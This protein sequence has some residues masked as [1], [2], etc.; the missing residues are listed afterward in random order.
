MIITKT[1][2]S[3]QQKVGVFLMVDNI[4]FSPNLIKEGKMSL[5]DWLELMNSDKREQ[6]FPN[7]CFPSDDFL[8]QYI[9][10][11]EKVGE[12]DFKSLL[13]MLLVNTGS[14][15]ID[16]LNRERF[17]L[18]KGYLDDYKNEYYRRLIETDYA[19]EGLTWIID[20]LPHF[21]KQALQVL[22]AYITAHLFFLPDNA[23]SGLIDAQVLI[24]AKY[25]KNNYSPD[26]LLELNPREFESLIAKLYQK[27]GYEVTLTK[28]T[29]DGG[30]DVIAVNKTTGKKEKL[31]IE[32]KRYKKK[33]GVHWARALI[34]TISTE[35]ITKGVLISPL[36]FTRGTIKLANQNSRLELIGAKEL[37]GL[38][39]ETLGKNW[40]DFIPKYIEDFN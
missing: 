11:I 8:N 33:V 13:R 16:D 31:Y 29:G 38:L 12:K 24:R 15:G 17:M 32:C 21:P 3:K 36:G 7:N 26:T 28:A 37:L 14:F 1:L 34:G 2:A 27:L 35:N 6:L 20:L 39:D 22:D 4:I 10:R 25:L 23:I 40:F 5:D 30:K 18:E 9:N 19:Y